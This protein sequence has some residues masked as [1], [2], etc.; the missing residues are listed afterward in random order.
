MTFWDYL[1]SITQSSAATAAL[2]HLA[3]SFVNVGGVN[4]LKNLV[5]NGRNTPQKP[6]PETTNQPKPTN[7]PEK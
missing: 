3:H 4:G 5:L 6:Q 2:V 7:E 1:A